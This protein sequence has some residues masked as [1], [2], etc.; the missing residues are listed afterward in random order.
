MF[1]GSVSAG[2]VALGLMAT[3]TEVGRAFYAFGLILLPTLSF[4]GLMT[5]ERALQSSIEDLG[6]AR[7]IAELRGY[8]FDN[9]PELGRYLYSVSPDQR[10]LIQGLGSGTLQGLRTV[11]GTVA[12]I[13]S[14]LA[15]SSVGLLAAVLSTS[16]WWWA[17]LSVA[18]SP[19]PR[20][21]Q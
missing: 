12:V 21:S 17:S 9:T 16:H 8:Y 15:G 14:V 20:W 10:L 5:F 7:R 6:Y 1:L 2:L 3:A 13:T 4:V 11:A 19:P 18:P